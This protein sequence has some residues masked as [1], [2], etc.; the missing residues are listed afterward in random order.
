MKEIVT[1][2]KDKNLQAVIN[3]HDALVPILIQVTLIIYVLKQMM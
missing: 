2:S 3:G 1:K